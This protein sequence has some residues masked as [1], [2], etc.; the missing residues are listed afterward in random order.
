MYE[1]KHFV[2]LFFFFSFHPPSHIPPPP[3]PG[4]IIHEFFFSIPSVMIPV[5]GITDEAL[6]LVV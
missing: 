4:K 2:L 3:M 6:L 5:G 1:Y